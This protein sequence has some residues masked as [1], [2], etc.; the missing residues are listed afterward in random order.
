MEG[1]R[2]HRAE[3]RKLWR[4]I[5][6]AAHNSVS[7]TMDEA[8]E[9]HNIFN[10]DQLWKQSSLFA[11]PDSYESTLFAPLQLDSMSRRV[12]PYPGLHA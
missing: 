9:A 7:T 5:P 4:V 1:A 2:V 8:G 12:P 10:S 11:D 3:A 6:L